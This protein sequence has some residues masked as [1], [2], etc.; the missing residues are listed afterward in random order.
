MLCHGMVVLLLVSAEL[1]QS[2]EDGADMSPPR[3]RGYSVELRTG[4][5]RLWGRFDD[6]RV[7]GTS[8]PLELS[9]GLHLTD[10]LILFAEVSDV[11]AFTSGDLTSHADLYGFGPGLKY[12]PTSTGFFL[13]GSLSWSWFRYRNDEWGR[14]DWPEPY[15]G[16]SGRLAMG[17]EWPS[18]SPWRFGLSGEIV[19]GRSMPPGFEA[20]THVAAA[21]LASIAYDSDGRPTSPSMS[22]SAQTATEQGLAPRHLYIDARLGLGALWVSSGYFLISS[23]TLP[24]AAAVGMSVTRDLVTFVEVSWIPTLTSNVNSGSVHMLHFDLYGAGLGLKYYLTP[25]RFFLS[26]SLSLARLQYESTGSYYA[27]GSTG[28]TSSWGVWTR[29]AVGQ[30]WPVSPYWSLGIAGEFQIG[31]MDQGDHASPAF[32]GSDAYVP[33]GLSLAVLGNYGSPATYVPPPSTAPRP[34]TMGVFLGIAIG[35]SAVAGRLDSRD[36]DASRTLDYLS[37]AF[38]FTLA[39]GYRFSPRWSA[40][41]ALTY[42]P[43]SL[44]DSGYAE[45]ANTI[46]VGTALRWHWLWNGTLRPWVSLG[47]GVEWLSF[48]RGIVTDVDARGYDMD[49]QIGGDLRVS[50]SWT[51]GP[52]AGARVGTYQHLSLHPHSRGGSPSDV[53][54]SFSDLA[55]HEWFTIGV[56]GTFASIR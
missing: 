24:L 3:S 50:R 45:S 46:R 1:G 2:N 56:R 10:D 28:D 27:D 42:A 52:Y 31:R 30:E 37:K 25:R 16:A 18:W 41:L 55:L 33:K 35:V 39:G 11:H 32:Y 47:P 53:D 26:A 12:Y 14:S 38:P 9:A 49:L 6:A 15:P 48:K 22:A 5:G 51:F 20:F 13:R 8:I 4:L 17:K 36:V 7:D 40:D 54:L 43:V 19:L 29:L 34:P 44:G 23:A 21:V